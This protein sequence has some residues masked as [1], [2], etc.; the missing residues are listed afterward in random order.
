MNRLTDR[1]ISLRLVLLLVM[2]MAAAWLPLARGE[3]LIGTAADPF[4]AGRVG[5]MRKWIVQLPFESNGYRLDRVDVD[6]W[7]VVAQSGDGKVHA[8]RAG[9]TTA[10][11]PGAPAPGSLLWSTSLGV[12]LGPLQSAG[13]G[14][15]LVVVTHDLDL[16]G[17]DARSG[18]V[19]WR[20]RLPVPPAVGPLPV[21][22]WVYTPLRNDVVLRLPVNPFRQPAAA[23][24]AEDGAAASS[25]SQKLVSLEPVEINS[26]GLIEQQP[27]P[28]AGGVIWC[29]R[30]GHLTAIEPA[31]D[32][33]TRHEFQ[34]NQQPNGPVLVRGQAVF[35]ATET[36]ELIRF[37]DAP[38][39]LRLTWRSLLETA[40]HPGQPRPQ[41]M[42]AGETLIVS[43][44]EAGIAAHEAAT[45]RRIWKSTLAGDLL[46]VVGSR[47][48]CFD[49][50]N[51]L[52]GVS[53]ATGE[54]EG[55][56]DPGPFTLPVTNRSSERLI[57]ASPRGLL[58]ALGPREVAG[59]EPPAVPAPADD[60]PEAEATPAVEKEEMPPADEPFNF[61]GK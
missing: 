57:L 59:T 61:F 21:G 39:G 17:L 30:N 47:L 22:D 26:H 7:T 29:T 23:A 15:P 9:D 27:A 40:L 25:S 44:G 49:R 42:L 48:W 32:A 14:G 3:C 56:L 43:L 53:V 35:A 5:L 12:P 10:T 24:S 50:Q 31:D 16:V 41:L 52:A 6:R 13:I 2:L 4:E 58:A 1:Q 18:S 11:R 45:G 34:L 46:A 28:Y 55:F 54:A 20:R 60:Q 36:G 37:E 51:M 19:F 8:V 33:W 38:G